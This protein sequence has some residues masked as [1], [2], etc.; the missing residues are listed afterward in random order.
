MYVA[1]KPDQ[2][3]LAVTQAPTSPEPCHGQF[4][5]SFFREKTQAGGGLPQDSCQASMR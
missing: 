3:R 2:L 1:I 4:S 5:M